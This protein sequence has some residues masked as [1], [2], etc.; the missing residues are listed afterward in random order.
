MTI[1]CPAPDASLGVALRL[2]TYVDCQARALGENGFQ[3]LVGGPIVAGLL[4]GL[5]TVFVALIGYRLILGTTPSLKDGIGWTVRLGIVLTLT[6]GWP[7][8]Q[9]LIYNVATD[10]PDEL[11]AVILPASG[12][13]ATDLDA[14]VQQAYDTIRLGVEPAATQ[15][16]SQA[17]PAN[18]GT[19]GQPAPAV[20]TATAPSPDGKLPQTASALVMST[21]GVMAALRIATG[22]LLA[23]G[24]LAI[25]ALLFD[26]TLGL[27]SGWVRAL[28]GAGLGLLAATLV[29]ALELPMVEGELGS[30]QGYGRGLASEVVD[31]QALTTMV[32][33]FAVVMLVAVLLA[34]RMA[35]AFSLRVSNAF[36]SAPTVMG[37]AAL[38]ERTVALPAALPLAAA[39]A[40]AAAG[41]PRAASVADALSL[42]VLREQQTAMAL[43]SG[44]GGEARSR[45][46][47]VAQSLVDAGPTTT[48]SAGAVNRRALARRTRSAA[49]RDLGA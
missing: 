39:A 5:V 46:L 49:A 11:A 41:R 35:G 12:L 32:L 38:L 31:P 13:P 25:L 34:I 42:S 1:A 44:G 20:S 24:P 19:P 23:V 6:T 48:A 21:S 15:P 45:A 30:I 22:F 43:V 33:L 18:S 17:I 16:P 36:V 14:R 47:P 37:Q 3:A 28:A 9:T 40:Q 8:F 10:G 27:F 7:A 4:S 2:S 26:A 29:T